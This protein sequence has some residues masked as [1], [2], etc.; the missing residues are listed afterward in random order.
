MTAEQ[1]WATVAYSQLPYFL[2]FLVFQTALFI[3][4]VAIFVYYGYFWHL[5][6]PRGITILA[7][8]DQATVSLKL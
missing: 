3:S 8:I 4:S 7:Q 2:S 5:E 1:N 6:L